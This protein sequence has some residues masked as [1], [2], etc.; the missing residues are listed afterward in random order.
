MSD[1][2]SDCSSWSADSTPSDHPNLFCTLS[3][4]IQRYESA[5]KH[6]SKPAESKRTSRKPSAS[7]MG[8]PATVRKQ[9]RVESYLRCRIMN[10]GQPPQYQKIKVM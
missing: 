10:E 7:A 1:H 4:N 8:R 3:R 9:S 6:S 2:L 5:S